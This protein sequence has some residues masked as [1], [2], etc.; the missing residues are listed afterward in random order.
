MPIGDWSNDGHGRCKYFLVESNK[1]FNEVKAIH[2]RSQEVTGIDIE[3]ICAD[4]DDND[5]WED[6]KE[7]LDEAGIDTSSLKESPYNEEKFEVTVEDMARIWMN[8]LMKT[9]CTLLIEIKNI[10]IMSFGQVGYGL[11]K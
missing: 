8:L 10:Q 11:F 6:T 2:H 7:M 4:F 3:N 9:D 1:D 5:I